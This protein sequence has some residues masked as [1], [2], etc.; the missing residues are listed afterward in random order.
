MQL[1]W[2]DAPVP[3]EGPARA[4]RTPRQVEAVLARLDAEAE[5]DQAEADQRLMRLFAASAART[6]RLPD[7]DWA[8][9]PQ[10]SPEEAMGQEDERTAG[11]GPQE[12][13]GAEA[14]ASPEEAMREEQAAMG[15]AE[16][17]EE[18]MNEEEEEEEVDKGKGPARSMLLGPPAREA[19]EGPG[20]QSPE[21]AMHDEEGYAA[22]PSSPEEAMH[23]EEEGAPAEYGNPLGETADELRTS[24]RDAEESSATALACSS[25]FSGYDAVCDGLE[26]GE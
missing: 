4:A 24:Q 3:R 26:F 2:P 16:S 17:P 25:A 6:W 22:A 9:A 23:Q 8:G 1:S 15:P 18:A 14:Q 11:A 13:D 7:G 10:R 19:V 20:R 21:E 12:A 5:A